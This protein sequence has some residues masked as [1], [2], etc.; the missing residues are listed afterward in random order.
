MTEE[1]SD[2]IYGLGVTDMHYQNFGFRN[3]HVCLVDY[4][5][6]EIEEEDY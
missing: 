1:E 3:G 4:A 6:G 2:F 5:G